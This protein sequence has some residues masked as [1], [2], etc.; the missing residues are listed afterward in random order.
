VGTFLEKECDEQRERRKVRKA[1]LQIR[2]YS[3]RM[4][5]Q[6]EPLSILGIMEDAREMYELVES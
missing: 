3:R 2:K 4:A 1:L 5:D 6:D